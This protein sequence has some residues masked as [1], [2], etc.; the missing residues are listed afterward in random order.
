MTILQV[1]KKIKHL[2]RK[3]E[4][5]SK[6]IQKWCSHF[7]NEETQ[8]D[9]A[10]LIQSANDMLEE[11]AR[12]RHLLHKTNI[13]TIIEF[14]G[15]NVSIDEL[16]ILLTLTLPTKINILRLLRRQEKGYNMDKDIKVVMNY[17]PADRDKKI[18]ALENVM[19]KA[20]EVLDNLNIA[21]EV[22]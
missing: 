21:T 15:K 13:Q 6:R 14:Q 11:K 17:D 10:K 8:Y 16:I 12:W 9:V 18:D 5:N 20:E 3:V 1:L 22:A 2:D 7:N 19:D 4:K